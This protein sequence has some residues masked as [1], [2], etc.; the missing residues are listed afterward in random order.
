MLTPELQPIRYCVRAHARDSQRISPRGGS[1]AP[2]VREGEGGSQTRYRCCRL[3][4]LLAKPKWSRG[5]WKKRVVRLRPSSWG[6]LTRA[7][8]AAL[9]QG[10]PLAATLAASTA[11]RHASPAAPRREV[12]NRIIWLS[13]QPMLAA[14]GSRVL[15]IPS[16]LLRVCHAVTSGSMHRHRRA[17]G[18]S[19]LHGMHAGRTTDGS[20]RR[21]LQ[22][23][24]HQR[25][26]FVYQN[27]TVESVLR[28]SLR[29]SLRTTVN[30]QGYSAQQSEF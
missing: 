2:T 13:R 22:Q 10:W 11:I 12:Q 3:P 16:V 9:W 29:W 19:G 30:Y 25:L 6:P 27:S 4:A 5:C 28:W 26:I 8:P 15:R 17:N 24:I 1:R 20:I 14:Q 23:K 7:A 21:A 18:P